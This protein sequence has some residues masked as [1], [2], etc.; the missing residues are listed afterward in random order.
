MIRPNI[1]VVGSLNMD[2]VVTAERMPKVGETILGDNIHYIP[3]GKG[4]NQAVG[5]AR[6]G[7][8]VG[9]IGALGDDPFGQEIFH[10]LTDQ[11]VKTGAIERLKGVSTG[12]ASIVHTPEDN[13]IIVVS[14]ANDRCTIELVSKY[15]GEIEGAD[16]LLLQLEIPLDSVY[17]ALV[18]AEGSGGATILNPA[19]ARE[20]TPEIL[21]RVDYLT[22]NETE[23]EQLSG[24]S[25]KTED[26]LEQKMLEWENRYRQRVILTRGDK[27]CSYLHN[28][29]LQTIP[30]PKVG[31]V[32]TIGAG[33]AFNAA[34]AFGIGQGWTVERSVRFAVTAASLS[35]SKFGAQSG[36]PTLE[37]V[38]QLFKSGF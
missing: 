35:V 10:N 30:A 22:P 16:V 23:F 11:G 14:G 31:V 27:G 20:L 7:A 9:M 4:A 32:D 29:R 3:G 26:E 8:E 37:E 13:C 6:L 2:L 12:I 33:D 38:E 34:L 17:R 18:I 24:C 19:P 15:Q 5:C 36:M 21:E 25:A 1:A 28:Q